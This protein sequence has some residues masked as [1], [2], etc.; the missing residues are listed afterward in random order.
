MR[1]YLSLGPKPVEL[2]ITLSLPNEV[3]EQMVVFMEEATKCQLE[4]LRP[5]FEFRS[6]ALCTAVEARRGETAY[7]AEYILDNR[8]QLMGFSRTNGAGLDIPDLLPKINNLHSHAN[9]Y[10]R[11]NQLVVVA[12]EL[13]DR[14]R[15]KYHEIRFALTAPEF[16]L[17][18]LH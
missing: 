12:T 9:M 16:D 14:G 4:E 7:M 8:L 5:D 13:A 6:N 3:K 1:L 10:T 11:G 17:D 2:P 15:H 18:E